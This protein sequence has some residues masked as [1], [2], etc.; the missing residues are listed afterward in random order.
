MLNIHVIPTGMMEENCS[1]CWDSEAKEAVIFD[2][3]DDAN[4]IIDYIEQNGLKPMA[5]IQTHCHYD[6]IGAI[7]EV[8][9]KYNIP[10]LVHSE[11]VANMR[12]ME[13]YMVSQLGE[14]PHH[15]EVDR[16]IKSD[17]VIEY[18]GITIKVI[19]TPGH[20]AG[21]VC[22]LVNDKHLITGDTL[23]AGSVGRWDF[24]GGNYEALAKSI[25]KLME[26]P[27]D[28]MIY[29]GHGEVS[30][31]GNEKRYNPFVKQMVK[32]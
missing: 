7:A 2:P 11:E 26:L 16:F 6:H 21:G 18:G 23:F 19:F 14:E 12:A 10:L 3:G 22:L 4:R 30:T 31:I 29:P 8:K 1:V 24:P 15:H 32:G 27:N 20:T 5:I 13:K 17:E 28:V 25:K 9:A